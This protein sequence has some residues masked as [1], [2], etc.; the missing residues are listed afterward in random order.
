MAGLDTALVI[1]PMNGGMEYPQG[2]AQ[3]ESRVSRAV[4]A[5]GRCAAN[6]VNR[7]FSG[8]AEADILLVANQRTWRALPTC[9]KGRVVELAE[10][11]VDLNIWKLPQRCEERLPQMPPR[12]LFVG[13]L[14]DWKRLDIALHALAKLPAATLDVIGDGATRD[15]WAELAVR[16]GIT[17]R[18]NFLGWL[19]QAACARL[20]H[21]AT[22]LLLP[23]I[24]ECGGAVVLEA[25]ATGTPVIA[26]DW[27]GPAD[28]LDSDC[29]MLVSPESADQMAEGFAAAMFKLAANPD[30]REAF[31]KAGR[32][33][34]ERH[35]DWEKKIDRVLE[36]YAQAIA[37]HTRHNG[38]YVPPRP[39]T[40]LLQPISDAA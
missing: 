18:V 21:N 31:G 32:Q 38:R 8:K 26:T 4:V 9:A 1:G 2:F 3:H 34:V 37:A 11:G 16:L 12:F 10:N 7:I 22:A 19:P 33:R 36:I 15:A 5:L 24:F 20:M 14:V 13:R 28:Y 40:D 17:D 27:G 35:Y 39:V 6:V 30:L 25:M 29:G 23:S